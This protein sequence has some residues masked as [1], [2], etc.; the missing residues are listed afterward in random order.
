MA[1]CKQVTT[2]DV[3]VLSAR[4]PSL[5]KHVG[6]LVEIFC[7]LCP[8]VVTAGDRSSDDSND[9]SDSS[10]VIRKYLHHIGR[11]ISTRYDIELN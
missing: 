10:E 9:D 3:Q 2:V 8:D 1:R 7:A 11:P 5:S 4:F 6:K